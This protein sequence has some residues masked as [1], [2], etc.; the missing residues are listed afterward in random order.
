MSTYTIYIVSRSRE[1]HYVRIM[2]N[3]GKAILNEP[4]KRAKSLEDTVEG[5][6]TAI[7][8]QKGSMNGKH[9]AVERISEKEFR[10][11][12]PQFAP[13]KG[14]KKVAKKV[15]EFKVG[16]IAVTLTN[17][18]PWYTKGEAFRVGSIDEDG[19]LHAVNLAFCIAPTGYRNKKR[20]RHATPAE[21][22]KFNAQKGK[23]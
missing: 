9:F 15:R 12:F 8:L 7:T 14:P 5:L 22:R 1:H 11:K 16:D 10:A 3:N 17:E 13:N 18:N 2:G 20:V 23:V 19:F 6:I 4:V 21:V